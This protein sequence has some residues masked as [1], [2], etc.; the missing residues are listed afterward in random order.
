M[1]RIAKITRHAACV[2]LVLAMLVA[3]HKPPTATP[4]DAPRESG[5]QWLKGDIAGAFTR[6]REQHQP[7]LLYWGA[8]WCPP[9]QQLKATVFSRPDF[10]AKTR[11]F[12]PVYLDGDEPSAQKWGEAFRV[13]GYPTLVILDADQH[14]VMRLAG[15]MDLSEYATVL[16]VALADLQPV[17]RTLAGIGNQPIVSVS[18]CDRLGFNAWTLDDIDERD[19][20]ARA[21]QLYDAA[22]R[23]AAGAPI[24]S[25]RLVVFAAY[26]QAAAEH[27]RIAHGTPPSTAMRDAIAGVQAVLSQYGADAK[28]ADALQALREPFFTA[29][30]ALDADTAQR[31]RD[32]YVHAM[33]AE[34]HH[35]NL[36]EADRI[37]ALRCKLIASRVVSDRHDWPPQYVDEARARIDAV[38]KQ[39][40]TPY[41]RASIVNSVLN[42]Y[43]ELRLYQPAYDLIQAELP[44]AEHPYYLKADLA[45][46]A[47]QLGHR[48]EALQL[49]QQAYQ[50]SQGAATRFQWGV[51][52][53]SALLR[54]RPQDTS[55]IATTSTQV[56]GELDGPDRIYRRARLR[57][58]QLDRELRAW[59][60]A[61]HGTHNAV[62]RALRARMQQV[63]VN[64]PSDEPARASCERF[65]G[66]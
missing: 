42:V 18:A 40:Q 53:V 24:S 5:I 48:D 3:C 66:A 6:A 65:L 19:Y 58:E 31:L 61:A 22:H 63:C 44:R 36:A 21:A 59:N 7:V 26:F 27:E 25:A 43:D 47:E 9:C 30:Q 20:T 35:P 8:A 54:L 49:W 51:N 11:L 39:Q 16:D 52:Y 4:P 32:T 10:I 56:L 15:G 37:A 17:Q 14:E 34:S 64:I 57:L 2:A 12:V 50:E 62:L 28:L 1:I 13:A 60:D 46:I 23:C 29:V 33:D 45:E 55:R 38:L 41:V